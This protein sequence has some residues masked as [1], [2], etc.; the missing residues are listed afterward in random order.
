MGRATDKEPRSQP[1]KMNSLCRGHNVIGIYSTFTAAGVVPC[2]GPKKSPC[3]SSLVHIIFSFQKIGPL[4]S[5]K[6]F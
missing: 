4:R 2:G 3:T 5:A 1:I 6:I